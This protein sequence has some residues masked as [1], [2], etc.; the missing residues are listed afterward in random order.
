MLGQNRCSCRRWGSRNSRLCR[1]TG[2]VPPDDIDSEVDDLWR[3]FPWN[4]SRVTVTIPGD[5]CHHGSKRLEEV[6]RR[7][8][9]QATRM[10]LEQMPQRE[11]V[12]MKVEDLAKAAEREQARPEKRSHARL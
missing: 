7:P 3:S 5:L 2:A 9:D 12:Q 8:M 10:D 1:A 6:A 11:F 4:L